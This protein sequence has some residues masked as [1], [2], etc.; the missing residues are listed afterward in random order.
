MDSE[1]N[2]LIENRVWDFVTRLK[3]YKVVQMR[4]LYKIKQ[5][6]NRKIEHFKARVVAKGY[7]QSYGLDYMRHNCQCLN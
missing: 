7:T 5:T 1:Y 2:S 4:W 6:S 3:A